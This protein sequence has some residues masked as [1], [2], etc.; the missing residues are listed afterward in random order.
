MKFNL[1]ASVKHVT[2]VLNPDLEIPDSSGSKSSNAPS[3]GATRPSSSSSPSPPP[4]SASSSPPAATAA[5]A[6]AA[7]PSVP[8]SHNGTKYSSRRSSLS[9][10]RLSRKSASIRTQQAPPLPPPSI[11]TLEAKTTLSTAFQ[12]DY[13]A[14][15]TQDPTLRSYPPPIS[16]TRRTRA[17]TTTATPGRSTYRSKLDPAAT[18]E[19]ITTTTTITAPY[20][21]L[22]GLS[23]STSPWTPGV[24]PTAPAQEGTATCLC[25]AVHLAFPTTSPGL[26]A[27]FVCYCIDCRKGGAEAGVVVKDDPETHTQA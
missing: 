16:S 20:F 19:P 4:S 24:P 25:G 26:V 15:A 6:A 3:H 11:S 21:G 7:A 9:V 5:A 10:R 17:S 12:K 1:A 22:T 14:K 2:R 27:S 18:A 23:S 8:S 13:S